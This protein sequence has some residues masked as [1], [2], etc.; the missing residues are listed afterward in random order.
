MWLIL[1][2]TLNSLKLLCTSIKFELK[3]NMLFKKEPEV[4]VTNHQFI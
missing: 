1:H 3:T 2:N 4:F